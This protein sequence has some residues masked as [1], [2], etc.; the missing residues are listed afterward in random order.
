[1][2]GPLP[3]L[4]AAKELKGLT[5]ADSTLALQADYQVQAHWLDGLF[6]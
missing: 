1:M 2:S 5:V 3:K 6:G 4:E